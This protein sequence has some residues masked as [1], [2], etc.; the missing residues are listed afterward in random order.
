MLRQALVL[1]AGRGRPVADPDT[2]NCLAEVG[3]APLLLRTLR[4]LSRLG[5]RRVALT[6]GWQAPRLRRRLA[7]LQAA[8]APGE[9]PPDIQCFDNPD[10]D[11]PNGLSVLAARRFVTEPT[12]LLMADQVAAPALVERFV[13][14]APPA[15][16]TV[17]GIDRELS[18]VF[19]I[20]D[21]TKVALAPPA[22]GDARGRLRVT[23]IGKELDAY[24]AVS[25]SLF[26]MSPSLIACLDALSE[27]SLTQ[28][29]AEAARRGLC[30]AVDVTGAIWQ[31]VDS[32]AMRQHADWLLRA[33]GDELVQ[34]AVQGQP[35][36]PATDTLAL[37]ER[38]L[39]EKDA[40]R[41]TL[42]NPGPV[43]TSARVKAA[44]VH[45][46]T[47]HRDEEYTGVVQRLRDKL[48]PV[49]G[50]SPEHEVLLV[51]GSG[52][53][54]METALVSSLPAG[55][56]LLTVSNGAFGERLGDVADVHGLPHRRLQL[57]WGEAI[58]PA[59]VEAALRADPAITT[60]AMIRHET[61][62]G[63]VNPVPAVGRACRTLD[64]LLVVDAV[65]ALGAEEVDVVADG[66][67]VCFSSSNKCLHAVAGVSFLCVS[68]RLWARTAGSAPRAYYLDLGRYRRAMHEL[69]QTPFTPAVSAFF[70]LETALDELAE[71]GG[72]PARREQYRQRNLRIRRVLTSLGFQSFTNTG[73]ESIAIST[74]R[75]PAGVTVQGLYDRLKERGFVIYK[76]KGPLAAD[77]IQIANMGELPE[78][79]LDA[80]LAALTDVVA[81]L[82]AAGAGAAADGGREPGAG[83]TRLRSV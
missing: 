54:A 10:W 76:A 19:D 6:V 43:M 45:H 36:S 53:A 65:S 51:T 18:R 58:D 60:V 14:Q 55:G 79:T 37:I 64:R 30:D 8:A 33:Y 63:L 4:G 81:Q 17:L 78:A 41:Y 34:P 83:R 67:D 44:L 1:A 29:V 70:A 75:V 12:L 74:V 2:P 72:V 35:Q 57:A 71:Q 47:C 13:A 46:D 61:S 80:F 24:E 11:R 16:H 40:A 48:R 82:Q 27:P 50:A 31:D 73:R 9:L 32:A 23:R 62:V 5:I 21:A 66:I 25:T 69:G 77:H 59:V 42:F 22:P 49:F 7:E 28:G 38:L 39:A 56:K 3:G 20:D 68:P 52:T 15:D 26:V